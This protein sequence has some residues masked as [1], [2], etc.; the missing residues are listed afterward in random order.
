MTIGATLFA[1]L[2]WGSMLAVFAVFLYVL[3]MVARR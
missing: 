1:V 2:V 3:A